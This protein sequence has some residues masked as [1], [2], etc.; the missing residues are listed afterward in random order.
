VELA[1]LNASFTLMYP[2][3]LISLKRDVFVGI[4]RTVALASVKGEGEGE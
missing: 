1:F 2:A 4:K 3:V